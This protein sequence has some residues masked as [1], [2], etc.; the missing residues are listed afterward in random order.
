MKFILTLLSMVILPWYA[1]AVGPADGSL[2]KENLTIG[3]FLP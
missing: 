2:N 1:H 3:T